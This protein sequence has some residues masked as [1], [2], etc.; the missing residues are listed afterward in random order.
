M[1]LNR[2]IL[3]ILEGPR[4]PPGKM[5]GGFNPQPF[6]LRLKPHPG[7]GFLRV[8]PRPPW[9]RDLFYW[10]FFS[11]CIVG[12]ASPY[13]LCWGLCLFVPRTRPGFSRVAAWPVFCC[14][15]GSLRCF[16]PARRWDRRAASAERPPPRGGSCRV[17]GLRF[18]LRFVCCRGH[19]R[20]REPLAP[21]PGLAAGAFQFLW[22]WHMRSALGNEKPYEVLHRGRCVGISPGNLYFA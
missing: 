8:P 1:Q 15:N 18:A 6:G 21:L 4:P 19:F 3:W 9:P 13:V 16:R 7:C 14:F 17:G 11:L 10:P 2:D 20:F 5:F 12:L 22:E